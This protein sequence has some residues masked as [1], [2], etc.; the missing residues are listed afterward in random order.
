MSDTDRNVYCTGTW[1]WGDAE[2]NC[3]PKALYS[4]SALRAMQSAV[5]ATAVLSVCHPVTFQYSVQCG[6]QPLV[7]QSF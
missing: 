6:V 1:L 5:L 4:A 3:V 7:G 2:G